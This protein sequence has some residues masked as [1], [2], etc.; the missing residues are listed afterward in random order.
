MGL[1]QNVIDTLTTNGES[2]SIR[3]MGQHFEH[4]YCMQLKRELLNELSAK[5]IEMWTK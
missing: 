4:F 2:V 3:V 1:E 5:V